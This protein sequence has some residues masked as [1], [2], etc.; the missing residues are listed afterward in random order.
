MLFFIRAYFNQKVATWL[1]T[2]LVIRWNDDAYGHFYKSN[3][4]R[5][6]QVIWSELKGMH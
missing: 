2:V 4:H 3:V 5:S 6:L 1:G